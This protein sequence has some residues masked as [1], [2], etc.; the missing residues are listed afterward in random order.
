MFSPIPYNTLT[1]SSPQRH[2]SWTTM[3]L[4][5]HYETALKPLLDWILRI[6]VTTNWAGPSP[7]R[8]LKF[9]PWP[10]FTWT[11]IPS[12][13]KFLA[14]TAM[15]L[16]FVIYFWVQIHLPVRFLTLIL[17]NWVSWT[18]FF[19]TILGWKAICRNL[20]AIYEHRADSKIF[21]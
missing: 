19:W 5:A 18:N 14:T 4:R 9:L 13:A 15:P 3:N 7:V 10:T 11:T 2:S 8:F 20:F 12:Q 17:V 21:G 6:L 1:S 16:P